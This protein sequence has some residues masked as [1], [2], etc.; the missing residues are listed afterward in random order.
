MNIIN[1]VVLPACTWAV[2][3]VNPAGLPPTTAAAASGW[4]ERWWNP[5][6]MMVRGLPGGMG[7]LTFTRLYI[8]SGKLLLTP[9][10][11]S[12]WVSGLFPPARNIS[13]NASSSAPG[14]GFSF[15][16]W[17]GQAFLGSASRQGGFTVRD[18]EI[19]P[20]AS[21]DRKGCHIA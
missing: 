4:P 10:L 21:L 15:E 1:N 18:G 7:G 9:G 13:D 5:V 8:F 14:W 19:R 20:G 16:C 11:L 2:V 12:G 6:V 3:A 17:L